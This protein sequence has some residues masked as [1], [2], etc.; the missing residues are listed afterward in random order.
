MIDLFAGQATRIGTVTD[1]QRLVIRRGAEELVDVPVA[2][3]KE[4]YKAGFE[5]V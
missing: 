1:D 2:E 3:L 4:R 5:G